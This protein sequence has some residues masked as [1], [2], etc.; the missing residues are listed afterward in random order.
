MINW[1]RVKTLRDEVGAEDFD[2]IVDIFIDEVSE[3]VDRLRKAPKIQNLGEDL[4]ALKGSAL[5]LGFTEFS[6]LCQT[7][8]TL[9]AE[10]KANEIDLPPIL[11][12]FD[13]SKDAFFEGLKN[14]AHI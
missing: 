13:N 7:G 9:A 10:G 5:N 6:A 14:P 1:T 8:E 12:C 2:D 11:S 3:M 4:H